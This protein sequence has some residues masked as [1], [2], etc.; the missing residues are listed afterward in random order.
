MNGFAWFFR[1]ERSTP[2]LRKKLWRG[3]YGFFAWKL[4]IHDWTFMNYGYATQDKPNTLKLQHTEE[5]NRYCIQLYDHLLGNISISNKQVAEI[6]CGRGGGSAWLAHHKQPAHITG[7]DLSTNAIHFCRQRHQ[8]SN[9]SYIQ[10]DAED[11]PFENESL[12]IVLNL[13]SSHHYP[14]MAKFLEEVFRVLKPGGH[15]LLADYREHDELEEFYALITASPF[16]VLQQADITHNVILALN[17][18]ES[19]KQE[20]IETNAPRWLWPAI[21]TFAGQKGY[22]VHQDFISGQL[23][24]V[25]LI[26]KKP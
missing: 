10:G 4:P 5:A 2:A 7:V 1:L 15:F 11:L 13:E 26:M 25:H 16:S 17:L 6:G 9:L 18:D 21:K 3:L 12:D 23:P 8:A 20:F 24:Y 14:N 19:R 22:R